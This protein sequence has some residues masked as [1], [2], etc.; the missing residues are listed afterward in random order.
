MIYKYFPDTAYQLEDRAA[1]KEYDG[2]IEKEVAEIETLIE[3][4]RK[5]ETVQT[6]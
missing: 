5:I 2:N 1:I 6:C 3:Y 4:R